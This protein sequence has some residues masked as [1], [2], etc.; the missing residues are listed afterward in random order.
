MCEG[1][2]KEKA[3]CFEGMAPSE[4]CQLVTCVGQ[5]RG[6]ESEAGTQKL[7]S[8]VEKVRFSIVSRGKVLKNFEQDEV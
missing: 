1:P 6:H 8:P 5:A 2:K 7:L 3:A 4:Y